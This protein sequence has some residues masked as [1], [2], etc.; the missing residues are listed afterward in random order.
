V[1]RLEE[2]PVPIILRH[3]DKLESYICRILL[4]SFVVLLFVQIISRQLFGRSITWI[5]ELSVFLFV[6]FAYLGA[7]YATRMAAHNRVSFH[8]AVLPRTHARIVEAM[9]DL[10]WLSFNLIF[11]FYSYD[12]VMNKFMKAQTLGIPMKWVYLILPLAFALM[13]IRIIQVNYLKLVKGIDPADPDSVEIE[14]AAA[15]SVGGKA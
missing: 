5:E 12:F 15:D 13:S 11:V 10:I 1:Y 6:W 9:G 4:A 8:L 3:I 2:T 7:S 14:I